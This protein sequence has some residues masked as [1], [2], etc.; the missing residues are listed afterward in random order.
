MRSLTH[1]EQCCWK[2]IFS[3][4][5]HF[6]DYYI[7]TTFYCQFHNL[8]SI[9]NQQR[10]NI[11]VVFSIFVP[12]TEINN[13]RINW[14]STAIGLLFILTGIWLIPSRNSI[15]RNLIINKLQQEI[16]N[17]SKKTTGKHRKFIYSVFL[18]LYSESV[19]FF[20]LNYINRSVNACLC[21][22]FSPVKEQQY[23]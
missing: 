17:N 20:F 22:V 11:Y 8:H 21:S 4:I 19:V 10:L 2:I 16:K 3:T 6:A 5:F 12:S 7:F 15:I 13:L 1:S 14:T 23:W 18:C 9:N